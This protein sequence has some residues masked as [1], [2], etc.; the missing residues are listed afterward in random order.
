MMTPA[1]T[2]E[3][4]SK[5]GTL[6]SLDLSE[7]LLRKIMSSFELESLDQISDSHVKQFLVS[8][9]KNALEVSDE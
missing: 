8:S 3:I 1:K 9:M 6:I 4:H 7:E 2:V 5:S